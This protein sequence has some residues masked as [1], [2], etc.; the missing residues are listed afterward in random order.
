MN[1]YDLHFMELAI[2]E[3]RKC[4]GEDQCAAPLVAAVA[5]RGGVLLGTAYRGER[6]PGQHDAPGQHAEYTLLEKKLPG[7]PLAGATVY[8]TLEPCT[9]RNPPKQP[10]VEWLIQR[11]VTRVIIGML[12]PN[13]VVRG[14][15]YIKLRDANVVTEFFEQALIVQ[16]EELNREFIQSVKSD[17]IN[18]AT[19][20]IIELATRSGTVGQRKAITQ[21]IQDSL[22]SLRRIQQGQLPI[23][24][25]DAGYFKHFLSLVQNHPKPEFAKAFIRATSFEVAGTA[26]KFALT[27]LYDGLHE[28]VK[29]GKLTIEYVFLLR[30]RESLSSNEVNLF[31]ERYK[32]FSK[33]I[34]LVFEDRTRLHHIDIQNSIALLTDR[35]TAFTHGRDNDGRII[36][37]VQWIS[38]DDYKRLEEQYDRVRMDSH[39]FFTEENGEGPTTISAAGA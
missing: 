4:R 32:T 10:C 15:G 14:R 34:R 21:T 9:M 18:I 35:R 31:I 37:A 28:A 8:T 20:E 19:T 13:P 11:K 7:V 29:S 33:A 6:V 23:T 12:D 17:P 1:D 39:P 2:A 16:L 38:P 3:A 27:G 22:K 24:G 36:D 25:G 30:S 5:V 26:D